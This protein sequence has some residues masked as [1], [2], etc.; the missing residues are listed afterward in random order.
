MG[1][2]V[3]G[4][5]RVRVRRGTSKETGSRGRKTKKEK[6]RLRKKGGG[7]GRELT[8]AADSGSDR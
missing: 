2:R 5:W 4:H 3:R 1:T 8:A 6:D 7:G